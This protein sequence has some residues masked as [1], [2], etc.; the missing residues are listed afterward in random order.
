MKDTSAQQPINTNLLAKTRHMIKQEAKLIADEEHQSKI[1]NCIA[2]M[3]GL[4]MAV[5][6]EQKGRYKTAWGT[7]TDLGL[8]LTIKRIIDEELTKV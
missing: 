4:K 2:Q 8:Y 3:L 7:K 5:R 6:G 1:G